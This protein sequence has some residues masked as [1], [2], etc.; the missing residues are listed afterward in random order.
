MDGAYVMVPAEEYTRL[1][2]YE[3][4]VLTVVEFLNRPENA[5]LKRDVL[6]RLGADD[7]LD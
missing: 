5:G 3:E 7:V 2:D 1:S 4:L 6:E